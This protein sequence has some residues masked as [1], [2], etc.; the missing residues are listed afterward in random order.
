L[1]FINSGRLFELGVVWGLAC[2][3]SVDNI[4]RQVVTRQVDH[5]DHDIRD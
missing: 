1:Q 4:V 5:S 3:D 2:K